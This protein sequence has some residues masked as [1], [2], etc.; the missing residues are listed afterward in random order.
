MH[1]VDLGGAEATSRIEIPHGFME[2]D[3]RL[4]VRGPVGAGVS[5]GMY[6]GYI[7]SG[8]AIVIYWAVSVSDVSYEVS[9]QVVSQAAHL[10]AMDSGDGSSRFGYETGMGTFEIPGS[11]VEL[12]LESDDGIAV[13]TIRYSTCPRVR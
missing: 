13:S 11:G 5:G 6:N 1:V 7:D 8:E 12:R 9:A 10:W 3:P 2:A 4:I